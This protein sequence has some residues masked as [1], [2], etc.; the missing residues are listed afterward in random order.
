MKLFDITRPISHAM[1]AYEGDP[2]V[3]IE[4][5]LRITR[6]APANV[7]RLIMGTHTGTHVDP[8]AHLREGAPGVDRLSLDVLIGPARVFNLAASGPIDAARLRGMDVTSH[9]RVLFK[10]R[11]SGG[12]PEETCP[13][14]FAGLTEGAA[15]LLVDSGVRL[16]GV[17]AMSVDPRESSSLPAHHVLLAAGVIILEGLSLC[18]VPP[19]DYELLCLPLNIQDG[20]GAPAR[21]V[22]REMGGPAVFG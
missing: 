2:E 18:A 16:V 4:P 9:R 20:D 1:P 7:S 14:D 11:N 13:S 10:T 5:W 3:S 8:P 19:G 22:L 15:R 17:D 12:C 21:V 6:G